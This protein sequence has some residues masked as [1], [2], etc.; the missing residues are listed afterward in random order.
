MN[1]KWI[2]IGKMRSVS[3]AAARMSV[4]NCSKY[5]YALATYV[6]DDISM[7]SCRVVNKRFLKLPATV[8]ST[9]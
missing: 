6:V 5:A 2:P 3:S 9:L 7:I 4:F 1:T 8:I